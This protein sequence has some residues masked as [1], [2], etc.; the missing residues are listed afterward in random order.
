MI[1]KFTKLKIFSIFLIFVVCIYGICLRLYKYQITEHEEIVEASLRKTMVTYTQTASRGNIYDRNG[2]PLVS[3]E[4]SFQVVFDYYFW[5]KDRQNEIILQLC[6]I[7]AQTE[8]PFIDTLPITPNAPYAFTT[9]NAD[10]KYYSQLMDFV[11][12]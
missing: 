5:E 3:N 4:M 10:N 1:N 12:G 8:H 2:V 7:M 6:A 11:S 9:A